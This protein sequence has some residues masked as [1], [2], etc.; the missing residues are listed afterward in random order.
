MPNIFPTLAV[1]SFEVTKTQSF[2]SRVQRSVNG[3]TVVALDQAYPIWKF[4]LKYEVLRDR[5]DVRG[6]HGAAGPGTRD[7]VGLD[8][9][10]TIMGFY[11][12][13]QG[14]F[15]PFLFDDPT[16]NYAYN[17]QIGTGNGSTTAFQLGR[18]LLSQSLGYGSGL[19]EPLRNPNNVDGIRFDDVF[20]GPDLYTVGADTGIVTFSPAPGNG[21]SIVADFSYRFLVRFSE[22]SMDFDYFMYQLWELKQL[23][24]DS[25]LP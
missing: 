18:T 17:I 25:V 21:V 2:K 23:K 1:Q 3:R 24:F 12:Q 10:R 6:G 7:G 14:G 19:F 4:Q 16:D 22:D 9:L 5:W 20:V 13:Q 11:S 8:E 15:V